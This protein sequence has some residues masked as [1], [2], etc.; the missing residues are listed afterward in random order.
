MTIEI[1]RASR[2]DADLTAA[3]ARLLPQFSSSATLPTAEHVRRI[4]ESPSTILLLARDGDAI[5][6]KLWMTAKRVRIDAG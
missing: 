2:V 6:G 5:V 1:T 3:I 4:I